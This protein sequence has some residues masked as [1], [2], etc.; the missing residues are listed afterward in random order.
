M[1]VVVE[2]CFDVV[3]LVFVFVFIFVCFEV[4]KGKECEVV[5]LFLVFVFDEKKLVGV[6]FLVFVVKKKFKEERR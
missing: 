6:D 3:D 5:F 4:S 2:G 1:I